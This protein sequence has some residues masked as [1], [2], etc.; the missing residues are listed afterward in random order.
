MHIVFRTEELRDLFAKYGPLKDVYV[1][2]DYYSRRPRGFCYVQ[3][4]SFYVGLYS[5]LW[6]LIVNLFVLS[7]QDKHS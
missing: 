1:P 7:D 4:P 3:Y 2:L 5:W 6:G